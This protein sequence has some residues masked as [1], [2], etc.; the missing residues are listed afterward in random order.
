MRF[1]QSVQG[2]LQQWLG[3]LIEVEAV[4]VENIDATLQVQ[5]RYLIRRN[6]E[7]RTAAF[8]RQV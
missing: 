2:S 8:S 4:E 6:Q 1:A 3:D 5:V 7:R